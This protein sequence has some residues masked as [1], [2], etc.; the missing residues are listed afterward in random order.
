MSFSKL[1]LLLVRLPFIALLGVLL[2]LPAATAQPAQAPA[3]AASARPA[4]T[5]SLVSP[6]QAPLGLQVGAT[7]SIA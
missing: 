4:L 2:E 6:T 7:G 1:L 5:V 3:S